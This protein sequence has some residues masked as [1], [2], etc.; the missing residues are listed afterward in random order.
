MDERQFMVDIEKKVGWG[1]MSID[2]NTS[3]K[4]ITKYWHEL[5]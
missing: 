2:N 1:Q 4:R 5:S 3:F